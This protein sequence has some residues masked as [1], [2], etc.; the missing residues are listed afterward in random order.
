MTDEE[1]MRSVWGWVRQRF[2]EPHEGYA[3]GVYVIEIPMQK[4]SHKDIAAAWSAA[5]AFTRERL[6]QIKLLHRDIAT[7]RVDLG[8]AKTDH[9]Q[10]TYSRVIARL[11][12]ELKSLTAGMKTE[13][14]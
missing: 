7:I 3:Q 8:F 6:D 9:T 4:F 13:K 11:E 5:A 12:S 1:Y 2:S 14:V 10:G